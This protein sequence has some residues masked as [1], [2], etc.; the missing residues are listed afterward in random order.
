M[1]EIRE[2]IA[3][4]IG[5]FIFTFVIAVPVLILFLNILP[6]CLRY[7]NPMTI[8]DVVF[9]AVF[10][11]LFSAIIPPERLGLTVIDALSRFARSLAE[12]VKHVISSVKR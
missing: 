1:G 9:F 12:Y 6:R 5:R 2:L 11:A 10:T 4:F 7:M 3:A 8:K